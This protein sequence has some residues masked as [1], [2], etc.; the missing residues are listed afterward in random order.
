MAEKLAVFLQKSVFLKMISH[1]F[2]MVHHNMQTVG[3]QISALHIVLYNLVGSPVKGR[4]FL[5][6]AHIEILV[7]IFIRIFQ[8]SLILSG[9]IL[10]KNGIVRIHVGQH[11]G[12]VALHIA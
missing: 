5:S 2:I 4:I 9:R 12:K 10:G 11:H 6:A 7:K 1:H 8:L 3:S